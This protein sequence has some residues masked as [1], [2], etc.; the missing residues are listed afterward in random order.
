MVDKGFAVQSHRAFLQDAQ[1]KDIKTY[2][3]S[4]AQVGLFS[5]DQEA[6][7][8]DDFVVASA[9]SPLISL[10]RLT[11]KGWEDRAL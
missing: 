6:V 8:E 2:G 4:R 7:L 3:K 5:N 9:A 11:Q 1:G 10:G